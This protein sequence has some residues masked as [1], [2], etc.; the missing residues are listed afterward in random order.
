MTSPTAVRA[1]PGAVA[2]R[3][4]L[5]AYLLF[6]GFTVWLPATVSAKVT[7]LV[8]IVARWVADA[9]IAS[10]YQSAFVL[11]ILANVVLFIPVG[12]LLPFV[13]SRL[14]LWQIVLIGGLMS[15]LIESVQGLMPSRFPTL[16]DVIANTTGTLIGALAAMVLVWMFASG[17]APEHH[18]SAA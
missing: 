11:E 15:V 18:R 6:V 1:R 10:Y 12:L 17:R 5:A 4:A 14:R 3:V 9:G 2:A 16:S 7:G 8:G 13:W